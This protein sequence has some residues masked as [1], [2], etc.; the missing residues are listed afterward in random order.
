M[1]DLFIWEERLWALIFEQI[2]VNSMWPN[3]AIRW[4]R[5]GSTLAQVMG[6]CLTAP[7]HYL[8][9]CWLI[10]SKV[11]YHSSEDLI[12]NQKK[13][14]RYQSVKQAWK[15]KIEVLKLHPNL[16]GAN[17]LTHCGLMATSHY[18]N[19]CRLIIDGALWHSPKTC[20]TGSTQDISS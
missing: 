8:N 15:L 17:E 14:W 16:P 1:W 7:S 6:C 3:D 2:L 13:L 18:L 19:H 12:K 9:Q 10:I 5:S 4:H 11:L 20:F